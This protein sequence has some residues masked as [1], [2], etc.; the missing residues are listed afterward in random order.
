MKAG[1]DNQRKV[2]SDC[3]PK[4]KSND[5]QCCIGL[6]SMQAMNSNKA[7]AFQTLMA[8]NSNGA[9]RHEQKVK[10][11]LSSYERLSRSECV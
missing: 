4:P 10:A 8:F 1:S 6:S 9:Q 2:K 3:N 11:E 5:T 7:R